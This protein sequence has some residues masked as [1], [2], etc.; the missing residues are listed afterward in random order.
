M[1]TALLELRGVTT[2]L[3][4]DG[5]EQA[6][7]EDISF[8]VA[9]GE[10]VGLVGESG[11]GK[12]MTA[13]TVLGL[14]PR[15]ARWE[16]EML[17]EGEPMPKRSRELRAARGRRMALIFQDPRAHIDPLYRNGEHLMEGLRA[18]RGLSR[19]EAEVEGVRLLKRVGIADGE[20][21]M[22]CYPWEISGGMLQRVL[23]AGALTGDPD[24]IIADEP[25]TA[26]D[27]TTQAEIAALLDQ[28]RRDEQ[29]GIV[30]I[31]HDLDLA[32][33]I[34]DRTIVMYAGRIMEE[35]QTASLF[36]SPAH[37]YSARLLQ[38]RPHIES[39]AELLTVIPGRPVSAFEAP[40]GCPFHPR[41]SYAQAECMSDVPQ[42]RVLE[43][44]TRS[45]CRR[46]GEIRGALKA[47]AAHV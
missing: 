42:L 24:L 31:T 45:A 40:A 44:T 11:S 28:L 37:P 34:C 23:I 9:R 12:S 1:S 7:I 3:D 32:A 27:V 30:F 36:E 26:L 10:I 39:R 46:I 33:A 29:R 22:R 17:L 6:V 4:L 41:C 25:T 21:V 47:E 8:Q 43:G 15:N 38:A 18:Y 5:D 13:R 2:F 20:R 16:G 35:H 19:S 14:L